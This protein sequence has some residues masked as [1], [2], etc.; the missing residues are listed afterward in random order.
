[1]KAMGYYN[2]FIVD[3]PP[4]VAPHPPTLVLGS[5][6]MAW[7][8]GSFGSLREAD[9]APVV[10]SVMPAVVQYLGYGGIPPPVITP[11]PA[12]V[13]SVMPAVVQY[14]G[15]GGIP[16]PVITPTPTVVASVMPAVVQYLAV[17]GGHQMHHTGSDTNS[18]W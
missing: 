8:R 9:L 1:M 12:V 3:V 11:T 14:L 15:Y 2:L 13:A 16:P 4:G 6:H 10:A 18:Q 5:H 7:V 17:F